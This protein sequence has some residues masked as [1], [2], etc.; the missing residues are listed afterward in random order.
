MMGPTHDEFGELE[1]ELRAR[2]S[3]LDRATERRLVSRIGAFPRAARPRFRLA[4]AAAM[5]ITV[6]A[7][8][9]ATGGVS[10]AVSAAKT[11]VSGSAA[12]QSSSAGQYGEGSCVEYVNPHGKNIPPAGL[13]PP[14]T[15]PKGGENPDGFYQIGSS[16]GSDVYVIDTGT[17][18]KF[19]PFPSGTVIKYTEANGKTPTEIKIGSDNGE[20][21]A[22]AAHISGQG[23]PAV[24]P[25]GGG[26]MTVCYVPPPPK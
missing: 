21:G 16:D 25:V 14:G 24:V 26:T 19:G 11:A 3:R 9:A 12:T 22:V 2:A 7:V 4:L 6:C 17:G 20:A 5:T 1:R 10:Y 13:T 8:L 23:D 18:T 15:N